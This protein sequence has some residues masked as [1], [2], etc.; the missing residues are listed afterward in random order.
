MTEQLLYQRPQVNLACSTSLRMWLVSSCAILAILQS[1]LT[2]SFVSLAVALTTVGAAVL[3]EFFINLGRRSTGLLDGSAVASALILTLLLP[4]QINPVIAACGAVF[5]MAVIKHS[6][7]G[8]GANWLNPALGGWLFIR[9]SWPATFIE[10]L[11]GAPM[12]ISMVSGSQNS[13]LGLISSALNN[14]VFAMAGS[15]LPSDYLQ[16]LFYPGPGIIGDRGL[17]ALILGTIILSAFRSGRFWASTL[18][19][20]LYLFLIRA[21][22]GQPWAGDI[23]FNLFTGG[24]LAAA[25]LLIAD[26]S[27]GVKSMGGMAAATALTALGAALLRIGGGEP[28][29]AI[30]AV[31]LVNG[32]SPLIRGFEDRRLYGRL[33]DRN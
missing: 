23:L 20:V 18:F 26:P 6:F 17:F 9:V 22:G 7:G 10:A 24:T 25:F 28:Y 2:D 15:E 1:S 33:Y 8:L 3:T 13:P 16:L 31:A 19:L 27:S 11:K 12:S 5:A 32:I 30:F 4:N 29:G 21:F 14:T